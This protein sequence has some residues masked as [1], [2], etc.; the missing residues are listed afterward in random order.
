MQD[1]LVQL[2]YREMAERLG[3]SP[4]AAR[5]KAKRKAAAGLWRI[6]PA[7]QPHE[8]DLV[9]LPA[10]ALT[11]IAE[12]AAE[13]QRL[14]SELA[15]SA[16]APPSRNEDSFVRPLLASLEQAQ[17]RIGQLTDQLVN[18]KDVLAS[19][20]AK[21]N[22]IN[23]DLVAAQL[24]VIAAKQEALKAKEETLEAKEA[25]RRDAMELTAAEMR[26]LGTKAELER[27][28]AD[29]ERLQAG[30]DQAQHRRR[31][32]WEVSRVLVRRAVTT[33]L[34]RRE[35]PQACCPSP[36]ISARC[37]ES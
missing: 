26:E 7:T 17:D 12:S 27:A 21:L 37:P 28:L 11:V 36:F 15:G 30:I 10:T 23:Y 3:V 16:T 31:F 6:I 24:E 18:A 14:S 35:R 19:A 34:L 5:L 1:D 20:Y 29:V 25:H 32:R 9:E 22:S 4:N 33:F 13:E 8:R 2:S